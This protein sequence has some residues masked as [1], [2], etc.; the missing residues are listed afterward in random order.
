[1]AITLLCPKL[2]CRAMLRVPESVRGKRVRCP[3]CGT[4]LIVPLKTGPS[5]QPVSQTPKSKSPQ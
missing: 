2:T 5:G 4:A 3:E 1:M